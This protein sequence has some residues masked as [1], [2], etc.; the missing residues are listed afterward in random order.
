MTMKHNENAIFLD[1]IIVLENEQPFN[2]C[3]HIMNKVEDI[4]AEKGLSSVEIY[5]EDRLLKAFM[6]LAVD[7]DKFFTYISNTLLFYAS[8]SYLLN[9]EHNLIESVV[10]WY[11]EEIDK[12]GIRVS[13]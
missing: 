6:E 3:S 2:F 8:M 11:N 10:V 13:A 9:K 5:F 12:F 1:N 4:M 7:R